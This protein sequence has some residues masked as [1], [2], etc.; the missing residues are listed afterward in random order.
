M[1]RGDA[2]SPGAT[3]PQTNVTIFLN[4]NITSRLL[5]N[6]WTESLLL[7][8]EPHTAS[9]P[10]VPLTDCWNASAPL[11]LQG[12]CTLTGTGTGKGTYDGSPGRPNVY[13]AK[14]TGSNQVTFFG[15]P[16]DPP[17]TTGQRIIRVTNVR[18]N[19]NQL[20]LNGGTAPIIANISL[21]NPNII[22]SNSPLTVATAQPG[23][24]VGAPATGSFQWCPGFNGNQIFSEPTP[25]VPGPPT[26]TLRFDEGFASSFKRAGPGTNVPGT[27]YNTESAFQPG[28]SGG[29]PPRVGVADTGTV[30]RANFSN[31]PKNV[32]L[33][34]PVN[35]GMTDTKGA[36]AG[37]VVA[38]SPT[39]VASGGNLS[40]SADSMG[41][42]DVYFQ[43]MDRDA[44]NPNP[45]SFSPQF[46]LG[47]SPSSVQTPVHIEAALG[48]AN[49]QFSQQDLFAPGSSLV[50]GIPT[51]SP[52]DTGISNPPLI[53]YL[54]VASIVG[55]TNGGNSL[56][57]FGSS[58]T[59]ISLTPQPQTGNARP[60]AASTSTTLVAPRVSNVGIVSLALPTSGFTMTKDPASTWLNASLSG[61]TTPATLFLSVNPATAGN[62]STTLN[63]NAS[64]GVTLS[65]PVS[66]S[67]RQG[68]WFTRYGFGNSASYVSDVVAPG[69]PFVIFGGDAFGP[70]TLAG[71]SIGSNGLVATTLGNTQVLF[72]GTPAPLYYSVNAN[73]IGQVA[74]FAPFELATKTQT[75]VQVVYIGVASPPVTLFVLDAVPGLYTA[76]SS[77]GG[78]AAALNQDLSVNSS[79]NPAAVGSIV[80]LYGGGAGQTNPGGRDGAFGGVGGPLAQLTLSVKVFVD[81]IAATNIPYAGP[82]PG[83]VEGVFQINV[84]I[85][86]GVHSGANVPVLVQI[87]DKQTQPGVTIATK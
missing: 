44:T 27:V 71:P 31:V 48:L 59:F 57:M 66:Y 55:C 46:T 10:S 29:F 41:S 72:D 87:E 30:L 78:Q 5:S 19:A 6:P 80:V 53:P 35:I 34:V 15:V 73:G 79:S 69:E 8:D 37:S 22:V 52:L 3:V 12:I 18:A 83:L 64:G 85:P 62:Y 25:G 50:N 40:V 23:L 11:D 54:N 68:P 45:V 38:A 49:S 32:T 51:F 2:D 16:I 77:G 14:L 17:G 1:Y 82:A 47:G 43:V 9:N 84:V 13:Q 42:A 75:N 28:S 63:F 67:V 7:I 39:G 4:T 81:G 61:T 86:P 70:P 60:E 20:G 65:V 58:P 24:L 56:T 33:F 26:F 76:D 36:T 21:G 74:G